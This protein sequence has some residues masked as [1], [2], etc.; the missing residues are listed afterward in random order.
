MTILVRPATVADAGRLSRFCAA[1][2]RETFESDNTPEDIS[3]YVAEA[4]T[5]DRQAAEIIDPAGT[6]LVAEGWNTA[7]D[8]ELIGYVH[9]L[10]GPAPAAIEGPAPVELKR[11]YVAAAWHGRGVAQRLMEAALDSARAQGAQTLWLGVWERNPRALAFYA[12]YGFTRVG[13]HTFV[14]GTDKQRD[15]LLALPLAAARH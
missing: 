15:W 14:L 2:F 12:K 8:A 6:L 9:L 13:E 3:R 5:P 1:T 7:G 11:L 4:F 10:A